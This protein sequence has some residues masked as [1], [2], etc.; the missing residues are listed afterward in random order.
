MP[1]VTKVLSVLDKG[2]RD[3]VTKNGEC[4]RRHADMRIRWRGLR[5]RIANIDVGMEVA[6]RALLDVDKEPSEDGSMVSRLT[7]RSKGGTPI[8]SRA[9]SSTSAIGRSISP[10]RKFAVRMTRS[11]SKARDPATPSL[12]T[13]DRVSSVD[14]AV[15]QRSS[16]FNLR[17]LET[18]SVSKHRHSSSVQLATSGDSNDQANAT[19]KVNKPRWNS[20]PH[21][22]PEA[23]SSSIP[24][25]KPNMSAQRP[26]DSR[27]PVPSWPPG[28]RSSS[29]LSHIPP[30]SSHPPTSTP[31]IIQT[32]PPSM[33]RPVSRQAYA[34]SESRSA[35]I[36]SRARP[37]TPSQIPAPNFFG[38]SSGTSQA[39]S[40]EQETPTTLMQ[41]T[42]SPSTPT[43]SPDPTPHTTPLKNKASH[44]PSLLPVPRGGLRAPSP[45]FSRSISPSPSV[46]TSI[47]RRGAQTPEA[48]L[49]SHAQQVPFYA[50]PSD[51]APFRPTPRSILKSG[52]PS[53]FREGS[54][55]IPSRPSS[56]A[57]NFD[58]SFTP[59][60]EQ[61]P[62]QPYV[63]GNPKDPLDVQIAQVCWMLQLPF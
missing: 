51:P 14:P 8:R 57:T 22:L 61:E 47:S 55:G 62:V 24:T 56:R 58:R 53:S 2:V 6:R 38:G 17:R 10:F 12:S 4:L 52:P 20:S 41:R 44:R 37:V 34:R 50:S 33:P 9:S 63:P 31:R 23:P 46:L 59:S 1:S 16:F 7:T 28:T 35:M 43:G 26:I 60:L 45:A 42:M 39:S 21:P 5:E 32:A 19:V 54:H 36:S 25:I 27:M 40:D 48:T 15:R 3:R 13:Q 49:R 11:A 30:S 29:R 18:A